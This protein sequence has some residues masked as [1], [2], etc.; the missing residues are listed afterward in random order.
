VART[1]EIGRVRVT[2]Y[3]SKGR[4]NKRIRIEVLDA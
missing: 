1:R 3:E 2:G 4:S